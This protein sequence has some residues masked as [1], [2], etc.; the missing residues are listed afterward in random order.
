MIRPQAR[1]QARP[2]IRPGRFVPLALLALAALLTMLGTPDTARATPAD[3][4]G[5]VVTGSVRAPGYRG[6]GLLPGALVELRQGGRAWTAVADETGRYR[7]PGGRSGPVAGRVRLS[8]FHVAAHTLVLELLL[9]P[10]GEIHVDLEL[11]HRPIL[12]SGVEVGVRSISGPVLSRSPF[13][14][15]EPRLA[16]LEI[17]SMEA[18]SGMVESGLVRGLGRPPPGEEHREPQRVLF[19]RGST[20][21]ARQF[22][23]DGAP[24]LAPFHLAGLVPAFDA[25]ALGEA[26]VYVGGAPARYEGGLSHMLDVRSRE[27]RRDRIRTEVAVDGVAFRG[28]LELP[29]PLKGGILATGR[30]LHGV[31]GILSPGGDHPYGFGDLLVRG[32]MNPM[33]GHQIRATGFLNRES[34][35]LR[36]MDEVSWGNRALS[37]GW[38]GR[39]GEIS[40]EAILARSDYRAAIPVE[41]P[42]SLVARSL[43]SHSR[44]SFLLR[45]PWGEG[46]FTV[47]GSMDRQ[48]FGYRLDRIPGVR[49]GEGVMLSGS[50]VPTQVQSAPQELRGDRAGVFLEADR[51]LG[52]GVRVQAGGR[53]DHFGVDGTTRAVPRASLRIL[54]T[55]EALLTLSGGR[56]HQPVALPG[57]VTES[58]G[59][60]TPGGAAPGGPTPSI[61]WN[62]TLAVA[63]ASHLVLSLDQA[64]SP[65]LALGVSGFVKHFE[66]TGGGPAARVNASG[67]DLR[68]SRDGERLEGW[69]GYA[70][71]WFWE[72]SGN[73]R[74]SSFTG[75]H[76]LTTGVRV[77]PT[78]GLEV[79]LSLG[80]GAGLPLTEVTPFAGGP[81]VEGADGRTVRTVGGGTTFEGITGSSAGAPMELA[82][83]EDFL[84]LD[85]EVS[86]EMRPRI[87]GRSTELRPY[88]RVIN[89]LDRRDALFHYF[90]RWMEDG[91]RPLAERPFLPLVGLEWRF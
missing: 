55:D 15:A 54:L 72:P 4:V 27:A 1:P 75:R 47:G 83:E 81:G 74:T 11:E 88:L 26:R 38:S 13:P 49:G 24:I 91:L 65:E 87:G 85:L 89:A 45:A 18:S 56:Y 77:R 62:P 63:S 53:V 41:W 3:S 70:I 76:L 37:L 58:G 31:P 36:E 71:S 60:A 7:L 78:E 86:W 82:P 35:E 6:D 5:P 23:L 64:L 73:G 8:A 79:G 28:G 90:D 2:Q 17:R 80:Y 84:R 61:F 59:E 52:P 9:P 48:G 22:L 20:V 66:G 25:R 10:A 39:W 44:A 16:E 33:E 51:R 50:S 19:A 57:L 30:R 34:V 68:I 32:A 43:A 67:T 29:L 40:T 42:E 21:D 12:L 14:A 69:A 46:E